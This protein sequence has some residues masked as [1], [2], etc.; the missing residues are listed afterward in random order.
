MQRTSA[1]EIFAVLSKCRFHHN[2]CRS[3]P[4]SFIFKQPVS[5]EEQ[6]RILI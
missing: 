5:F 1:I 2:H 4:Q 3:Q 6:W